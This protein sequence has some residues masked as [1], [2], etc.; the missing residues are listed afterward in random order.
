MFKTIAIRNFQKPETGKR[1]IDM[2]IKQ[3]L[4]IMNIK[5]DFPKIYAPSSHT[6]QWYKLIEH[7]SLPGIGFIETL[8]FPGFS[9]FKHPS[10]KRRKQLFSQIP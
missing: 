3:D 5:E 9:S 1:W 4:Q 8:H 2:I 10:L 7:E 6:L